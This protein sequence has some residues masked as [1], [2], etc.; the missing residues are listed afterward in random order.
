[1]ASKNVSNI[2]VN[3]A[4]DNFPKTDGGVTIVIENKKRVRR[5]FENQVREIQRNERYLG[6][7]LCSTR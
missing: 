2:Y 6:N 7:R 1:M 5:R 3:P 4:K